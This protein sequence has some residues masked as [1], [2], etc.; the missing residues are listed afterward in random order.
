M[1][2]CRLISAAC[3]LAGALLPQQVLAHAT[4]SPKFTTQGSYQRLAFGITHGCE[5]SATIEVIIQLPESIMGAKP[6]PKAGWT[7][8]TEVQDL[9]QPYVSH[10]KEIRRDVRSIRWRGKLLDAHYD[11]FVVM[12]KVWNKPG[13]VAIPV[14]QLCEKGRM[15]W[16]QLPD[17]SGKRTEY[18]APV[19]EI[20]PGEHKH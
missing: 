17:G 12:T 5:G 20:M 10:G 7:V 14:T 6:M 16:N 11:E 15:D 9:A 18:P 13:P 1:K 3:L 19:L 8:D 4:V 2:R